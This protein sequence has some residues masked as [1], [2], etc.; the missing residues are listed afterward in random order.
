MGYKAAA[1][2]S[3]ACLIFTGLFKYKD[4]ILRKAISAQDRL[5]HQ[6]E[7]DGSSASVPDMEDPGRI[8]ADERK[9][10]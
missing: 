5:H 4:S 7:L 9:D 2:F 3:V 8:G 6:R 1:A 10:K